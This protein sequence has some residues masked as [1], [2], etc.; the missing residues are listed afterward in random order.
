MTQHAEFYRNAIDLNRYSNSVTRRIVRAYNDVIV[1]AVERLAVMDPD[2][3]SAARLRAIL[4]QLKESLGTWAGT[5]S[6]M[7]T[8]ELQ[9]LAILQADFMVDQLERMVPPSVTTSIRSVEISPQFAQAVVTSDPTQLG[10]VSLSDDLPGAARRQF[11]MTVADGTTLTLPNGEVVRK[12]FQSMS[13]SQAELFS[14]AVRN[15]LLTGESMPSI[16]RRLKGRLVRD[17]RSSVAQ[18]IQKGGLVTARANNQIRAI[19]RSSITQVT[20]A[21]REQVALSNPDATT[22]YIYRAVLDSRT[23]AICRSLDGK[24]YKW[25]EGPVPP[26]HFGCRSLRAPLIKGLEKEQIEEF[27][28]YGSWLQQNPAEKQ[29]VFGSKA[30]YFDYLANKY[31]AKDALR[32]F[33]SKDGSELTLNQLAARYPDVKPR[34]TSS[35]G[36]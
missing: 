29:K 34:T 33:V 17:D 7:M 35:P 22:R 36:Q 16:V 4:A 25:G 28:D 21:A 6:L 27:E 13:T 30:P 26:L 19:V 10:I 1:D 24:V 9:G 5:S 23:T 12:A 15:G 20:D 32:R 18:Q 11:V 14:Q 8:E 31:G 2:S 3:I